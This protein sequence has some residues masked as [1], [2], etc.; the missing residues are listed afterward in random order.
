MR[1]KEFNNNTV[2]TILND[3]NAISS[4]TILCFGAKGSGKT[5]LCE[6]IIGE[7]LKQ[8]VTVI[9]IGDPKKQNELAYGLFEPTEPY[10]LNEL[11]KVG[12][13]KGKLPLKIYH[14]FTFNLPRN[15]KMY[16]MQYY[17]ISIKCL[18]REIYKFILETVFDN[19]HIRYLVNILPQLNDKD[20]LWDLLHKIQN[21]HIGKRKGDKFQYNKNLF[22][23]LRS[24]G[25]HKNIEE[26]ASY[27]I[28]FKTNYFLN[29]DKHPMNLDMLKIC[30]DN[31]HVHFFST[32]YVNDAKMEALLAMIL[33]D[34]IIQ[35]QHHINKKLLIYFP[36]LKNT[37]PLKAKGFYSQLEDYFAKKLNLIRSSGIGISFLGDTQTISDV[38]EA[39]SQNFDIGL[40]GHVTSPK[41][42]A[43]LS[44]IFKID[45]YTIRNLLSRNKKGEFS[46]LGIEENQTFRALMPSHM[47]CEEEYQFYNM[48]KKIMPEKMNYEHRDIYEAIRNEFKS[49]DDKTEK[50][51]IKFLDKI[52]MENEAKKEKKNSKKEIKIKTDEIVE[53]AKKKVNET[54][55][56]LKQLVY[57]AKVKE[58]LSFRKL[59]QKFGI[60]KVTA[61]RYYL[62]MKEINENKRYDDID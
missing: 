20:N 10:H 35:N 43:S 39:I 36:E 9:A 56:K 58:D 31:K 49:Y 55:E 57:E 59:S 14:P 45:V 61:K 22:N 21:M 47:H 52:K 38:N 6:S 19:L 13:P 29:S 62:E 1:F 50:D 17:T 44:K 23:V 11:R 40:I 53:K 60:N 5:T 8:G 27:F 54:K 30:N 46:V 48:Y 42:L 25:K 4:Y 37:F 16:P 32:T 26:L 2:F 51:V 41:D 18:S 28:D 33:F 3:W 15:I 34:M 24:E 7:F 12:K